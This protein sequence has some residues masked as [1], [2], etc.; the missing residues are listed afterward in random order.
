MSGLLGGLGSLVSP[1]TVDRAFSLA[2]QFLEMQRRHVAA[3]ERMADAWEHELGMSD[4]PVTPIATGST[5]RH[6][7]AQAT[8]QGKPDPRPNPSS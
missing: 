6:L 8:Q 3:L 7:R 4:A 5:S 1:A 2:E